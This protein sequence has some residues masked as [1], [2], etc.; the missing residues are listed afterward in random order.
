[1]EIYLL[2]SFAHF[3]RNSGTRLEKRMPIY[4]V[5]FINSFSSKFSLSELIKL[6]PSDKLIEHPG[7][8][9]MLSN[10][11]ILCSGENFNKKDLD[12]QAVTNKITLINLA[13]GAQNKGMNTV[14]LHNAIAWRIPKTRDYLFVILGSNLH[15]GLG[16]GSRNKETGEIEFDKQ[17]DWEFAGRRYLVDCGIQLTIGFKIIRWSHWII[18]VNRENRFQYFDLSK[19]KQPK[20][21]PSQDLGVNSFIPDEAGVDLICTQTCIFALTKKKII[22]IPQPMNQRKLL[23]KVTSAQDLPPPSDFNNYYYTMAASPNFV[24]VASK[25]NLIVLSNKSL[26]TLCKHVWKPDAITKGRVNLPFRMRVINF[27]RVELLLVAYFSQAIQVFAVGRNGVQQGNQLVQPSSAM[28][29]PY[30]IIR[31]LMQNITP[32]LSDNRWF[33]MLYIPKLNSILVSGEFNVFHVAKLK[34]E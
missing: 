12:S 30:S 16:S 18:F 32:K 26:T 13:T 14:S 4:P 1:M 5:D 8:V 9:E 25:E 10:N 34:Y 24:Y 3:D 22:K 31:V 33:D 27:Q 7:A 15:I 2:K 19:L 28:S 21:L 20:I 29:E 6:Q 17:V 23:Q 11:E